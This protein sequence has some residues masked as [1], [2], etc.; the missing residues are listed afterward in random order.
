M[1]ELLEQVA[2]ENEELDRKRAAQAGGQGGE[3]PDA[4]GELQ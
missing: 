2:K 4:T 3:A 1:M